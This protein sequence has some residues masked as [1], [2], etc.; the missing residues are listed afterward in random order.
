LEHGIIEQLEMTMECCELVGM[1]LMQGQGHA[2]LFQI[3]HLATS[4][5]E[6]TKLI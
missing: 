6:R 4:V 2:V 5:P 3:N 1:A